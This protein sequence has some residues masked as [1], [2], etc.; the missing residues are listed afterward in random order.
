MG[1]VG[2]WAS[3]DLESA[4]GTRP[5]AGDAVWS[6]EYN[7]SATTRAYQCVGAA[8]LETVQQVGGVHQPGRATTL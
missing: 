7:Q 3:P 4:A 8:L 6:S 2:T 1:Q 5:L